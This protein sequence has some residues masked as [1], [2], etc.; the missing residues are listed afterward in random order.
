[1]EFSTL[2]EIF[3]RMEKTSKRIELTDI[4]V[5]LLKKNTKRDTPKCCISFTGYH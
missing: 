4:L 5:E 1:M 3:Q 2:S